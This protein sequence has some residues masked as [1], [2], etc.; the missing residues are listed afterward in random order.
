[1]TA[2]RTERTGA[3][4]WHKRRLL[5]LGGTGEAA[6]L[7]EAVCAKFGNRLDVVTSLAGRTKHPAAIA[8]KIRIGGFGGKDGL[9]DYL[10]EDRV[11]L[12]IDATH[13]FAAQISAV[14]RE[15]CDELGVPRLLLARASWRAGPG[16]NWIEAE[17]AEAAAKLLPNLGRRAFLT[18][19]RRDLAPFGAVR[20]CWFLVRLVEKPDEPL[21]LGRSGQD[22]TLILARGPFTVADERRLMTDHGID[23]LVTKASGGAA[24]AAKLIAA[25]E[26][27][28]PVILLRRPD[29][30]P[31][32]WAENLDQALKW[33]TAHL[34]GLKATGPALSDTM[35]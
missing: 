22:Y 5:I 23:V 4:D 30:E 16:D 25:R 6:A 15:A 24:T 7:A 8:G 34:A 19:G 9:A 10:R 28:L 17:N 3:A 35:Q 20:G 29:Q 32:D 1:M 2:M 11:D 26:L 31:G 21:P 14:A 27:K 33:L 12:V 13:P 18:V